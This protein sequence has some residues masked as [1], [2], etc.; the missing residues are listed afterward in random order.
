MLCWG[1][2][3]VALGDHGEH[4]HHACAT[5]TTIVRQ[6]TCTWPREQNCVLACVN[7]QLL[8]S[9]FQGRETISAKV[10]A[11]LTTVRTV[12]ELPNERTK[13]SIL[14]KMAQTGSVSHSIAF[15]GAGAMAE[16]LAGGWVA[17]G[18]VKP[19][20]LSACDPAAVRREVFKSMGITVYESAAQVRIPASIQYSAP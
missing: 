7:E 19:E 6:A 20:Q 5:W 17:K 11:K 18:I 16:A 3:W 12:S 9:P 8:R 10:T 15:I 4:H 13:A 1:R 14:S 2:T